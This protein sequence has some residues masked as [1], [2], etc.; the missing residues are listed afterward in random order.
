MN[1]HPGITIKL[2]FLFAAG[3]AALSSCTKEEATISLVRPGGCDTTATMSYK[4][5]I[6]KIVSNSCSYSPCHSPGSGNYDYTRYEVLA[7]RIRSGR[8]EERLL[9]SSDEPLHMPQGFNLSECD[10]YKIRLWI[11]QGFP[12]N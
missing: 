5:D 9:L 4:E 11:H 3:L 8:L 6:V 12:N 1:K 10:L 7:D 2:F